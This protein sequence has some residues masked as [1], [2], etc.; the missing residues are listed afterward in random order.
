MFLLQGGI[1]A[2]AALRSMPGPLHGLWKEGMGKTGPFGVCFQFGPAWC[3]FFC[4][5]LARRLRC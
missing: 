4:L 5:A 2:S 1:L 3:V